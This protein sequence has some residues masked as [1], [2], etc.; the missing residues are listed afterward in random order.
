ML[1]V[2][3]AEDEPPIARAVSRMIEE[4]SPMFKVVACESNGKE[5]L[6]Y[7]RRDPVD[8]VLTDIRMPVMDGLELLKAIR[9][10]WPDCLIVIISGHQDFE[11]TQTALRFGAFD[12]LLKPISREKLREMLDRLEDMFARNLLQEAVNLW[13]VG[14]RVPSIEM[15]LSNDTT[16]ALILA[17]A[18]HWPTIADDALSP[19]AVFWQMNDPDI[20]IRETLGQFSGAVTFVGRAAAERVF[21]LE[22]T[23]AEKAVAAAEDL[24]KKLIALSPLSKTLCVVHDQ[25]RFDDITTAIRTARKRVY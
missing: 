7:M 12:Y 5:A 20:L 8:M 9:A 18:G 3:I 2:L 23:T 10:N 21:L 17:I 16:Y 1:K 24:L 19:G 4:L 6:E 25:L 15:P 11:Y 14:G 13:R 22:N